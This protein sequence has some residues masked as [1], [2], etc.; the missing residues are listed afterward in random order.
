MIVVKLLVDNSDIYHYH[1]YIH[2][3]IYIDVIHITTIIVSSW[4]L[5]YNQFVMI[6]LECIYIYID[7]LMCIYIYGYI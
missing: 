3:Y 4:G 6:L 2:N 7:I 1:I 5:E